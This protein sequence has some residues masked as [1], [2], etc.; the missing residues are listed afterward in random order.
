MAKVLQLAKDN[1]QL[2]GSPIGKYLSDKDTK[3]AE[4]K[5]LRKLEEILII[6]AEDCYLSADIIRPGEG[7]RRQLVAPREANNAEANKRMKTDHK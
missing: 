6:L 7:R 4:T 2:F 1:V 3:L 5:R